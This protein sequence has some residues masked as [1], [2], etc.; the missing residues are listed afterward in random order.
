MNDYVCD[1]KALHLKTETGF[2]CL[3]SIVVTIIKINKLEKA[4]K[5][6]KYPVFKRILN[7]NLNI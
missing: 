6:A 1:N 5:C 2:L 3:T 7:N 4:G